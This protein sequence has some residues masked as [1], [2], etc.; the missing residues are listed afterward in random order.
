MAKLL[1][2]PEVA[3]YLRLSK[4][5][6]YKMVESGRIP[7]LK[8]GSQWRFNRD[9]IDAWMRESAEAEIEERRRRQDPDPKR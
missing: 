8:A 7:A 9:E 4:H 1:T 2:L 3:E 5:T 6:L